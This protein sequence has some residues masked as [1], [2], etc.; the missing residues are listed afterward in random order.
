MTTK[1][2][3]KATMLLNK[4]SADARM[5]ALLPPEQV[6]WLDEQVRRGVHR[7]RSGVVRE[8]LARLMQAEEGV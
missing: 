5:T 6:A 7:S 8:I 3:N 2:P 4:H 1:Q